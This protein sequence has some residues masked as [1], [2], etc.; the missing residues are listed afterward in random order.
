MQISQLTTR[1]IFKSHGQLQLLFGDYSSW[2][3]GATKKY[4]NGGLRRTYW[5]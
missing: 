2:N 1:D 4:K 5:S 3:L